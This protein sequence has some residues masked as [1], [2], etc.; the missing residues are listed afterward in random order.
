MS[1]RLSEE[2]NP[3]CYHIGIALAHLTAK[4]DG[5]AFSH[6]QKKSL[7]G[8]HEQRG[9]CKIIG[10]ESSCGHGSAQSIRPE[11]SGLWKYRKNGRDRRFEFSGL[12]VVEGHSA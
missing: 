12:Q 6:S 3:H 7:G 9:V 2:Q 11:I 5:R 8:S 4:S 1:G 10:D